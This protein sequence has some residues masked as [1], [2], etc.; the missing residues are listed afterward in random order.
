LRTAIEVSLVSVNF[1]SV[2]LSSMSAAIL[3]LLYA[4]FFNKLLRDEGLI[5]NNEPFKNLLTQ[6]MVLKDGKL[7]IIGVKNRTDGR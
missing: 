5:E 6:G 3:H 2:L 1:D 7:I 4:R